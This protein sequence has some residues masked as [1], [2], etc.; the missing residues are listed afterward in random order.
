MIYLKDERMTTKST[1]PARQNMVHVGGY[2]SPEVR[3][4]VKQL[5]LEEDKTVQALIGEALNMLFAA[6]GKPEIA[7]KE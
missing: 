4:M 3:K 5:A 6:H 2:F 1:P 7:P